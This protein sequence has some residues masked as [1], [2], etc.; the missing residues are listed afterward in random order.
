METK[1]TKN[2]VRRATARG[3]WINASRSTT[4]RVSDCPDNPKREMSEIQTP[5]NGD[6]GQTLAPV[7]LLAAF[8]EEEA[9]IEEECAAMEKRPDGYHADDR[10]GLP[11][12]RTIVRS[13]RSAAEK[14]QPYG[15]PR[16]DEPYIA[17]ERF[18]GKPSGAS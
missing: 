5:E 15:K 7:S 4:L 10:V 2:N 8:L 6:A 18:V 3:V 12:M 9:W 13:M 14:A 16:E 1:H 17:S 11:Y